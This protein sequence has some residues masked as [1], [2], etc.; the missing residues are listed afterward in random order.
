MADG[1]HCPIWKFALTSVIALKLKK[2]ENQ[3]TPQN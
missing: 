1:E 3:K 2:F